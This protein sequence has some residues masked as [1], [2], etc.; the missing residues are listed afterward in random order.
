MRDSISIIVPVYNVEKYLEKCIDSILNQSY[1]NLEIILID[2]GSTDNSGSI[3]DEYKKKI[4]EYRLSIRKTKVSQ[5][6]V[7]LD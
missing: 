7:M 2:D 4:K 1:Q 6:H 3:C 5:V